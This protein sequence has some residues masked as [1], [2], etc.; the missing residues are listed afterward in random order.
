MVG[1]S[2][3]DALNAAAKTQKRKDLGKQIEQFHGS[4]LNKVQFDK[5][6]HIVQD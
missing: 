1:M 6:G 2:S 3:E 5:E 4:Q